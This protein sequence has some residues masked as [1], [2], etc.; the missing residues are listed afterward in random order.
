MYH[1]TPDHI[2]IYDLVRGKWKDTHGTKFSLEKGESIVFVIQQKSGNQVYLLTQKNGFL[3]QM[4]LYDISENKRVQV[5][6]LG[7]H[8]LKDA[9]Q[10]LNNNELN[11]VLF[12]DAGD[13]LRALDLDQLSFVD[14]PLSKIQQHYALE[15][16]RYSDVDQVLSHDG[17]IYGVR[18]PGSLQIFDTVS[19]HLIEEAFWGSFQDIYLLKNR[20]VL[21]YDLHCNVYQITSQGKKVLFRADD[22]Q[23]NA[24]FQGNIPHTMFY[25]EINGNYIFVVSGQDGS[26]RTQKVIVVNGQKKVI[27][28][29]DPI[30]IPFN[31]FSCQCS[32][33]RGELI[34]LFSS[35]DAKLQ[36][37][38]VFKGDYNPQ[39]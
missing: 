32:I 39:L 37:T 21:K 38:F 2:F 25:D 11:V 27:R 10:Y 18:S 12:R 15:E 1:F 20:T 26:F 6:N 33:S 17:Q 5:W 9:L 23:N 7:V 36:R 13:G 19:H 3:A 35:D 31:G 8:R 24:Y 28:Y 14:L 16:N 22:F 4:M 29:S 34:L 30:T